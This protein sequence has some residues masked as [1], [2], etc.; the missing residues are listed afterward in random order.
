MIIKIAM[1]WEYTEMA[2]I[3]WDMEETALMKMRRRKI[4]ERM[5]TAK[6]KTANTADSTT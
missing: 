4:M 1:K 2:T 5:T 6:I 3:C